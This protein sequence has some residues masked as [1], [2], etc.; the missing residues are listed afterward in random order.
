MS[1]NHDG[2]VL[3]QHA[4]CSSSNCV[5]SVFSSLYHWTQNW[6]HEL[7]DANLA[8]EL[9][10]V[11][12]HKQNKPSFW[13]SLFQQLQYNTIQYKLFQSWST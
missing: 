13:T 12:V 11:T 10:S 4:V 5:G 3:G 9:V 2:R 6:K 7:W 8:E 1:V